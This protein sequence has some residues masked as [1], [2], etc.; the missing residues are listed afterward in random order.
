METVAL[1]AQEWV[2]QR[3]FWE[4]AESGSH[5]Y[6]LDFL[7]L[8]I[9]LVF[10][11][12]EFQMNLTFVKTVWAMGDQAELDWMLQESVGC[13]RVGTSGNPVSCF[14]NLLEGSS[15][16]GKGNAF[17]VYTLVILLRQHLPRKGWEER[18][19]QATQ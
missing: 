10:K 2:K 9:G 17:T 13:F 18:D 15:L 16:Y 14:T 7:S 3:C 6:K 5:W 12:T 1:D 8:G 11:Q 4:R 19:F